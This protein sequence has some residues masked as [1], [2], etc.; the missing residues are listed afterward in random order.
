MTTN[1]PVQEITKARLSI[2]ADMLLADAGCTRDGREKSAI[3]WRQRAF[4]N[5]TCSHT[6]SWEDAGKVSHPYTEL[7]VN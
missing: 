1:K 5:Y 6:P 3:G 4:D 2:Q 7:R